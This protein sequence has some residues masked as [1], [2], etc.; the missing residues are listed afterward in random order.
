[1]KLKLN[2]SIISST[3]LILLTPTSI[4]AQARGDIG[5]SRQP[6]TCPSRSEPRTGVINSAQAIKYATCEAEADRIIRTPGRTN[7]IDISSLEVN[8]KPRQA[9][10]LDINYFGKAIANSPVYDVRGT[11]VAYACAAL[12]NSAGGGRPG[13]NCLN[14]N[15][16]DR[17]PN[18]SVGVCFR[19]PSGNW[20]C[21]LSVGGGKGLQYGPPP[22]GANASGSSET[23]IAP[24]DN[25]QT[26]FEQARIKQQKKDYRGSLA[27]LNRAIKISPNNADFYHYRA[28]IKH[29]IE[30]DRGSLA[31]LNRAIQINPNNASFYGDRGRVKLVS[32]KDRS[33][34]IKDWQQAANLFRQQGDTKQYQITLSAI[35]GVKN[36]RITSETMKLK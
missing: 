8:P 26:Y 10:Y 32:L 27:D 3:M 5:T 13:K 7:F 19:E 24:N 11:A 6:Q 9:E 36:G 33:G 17:G 22:D 16:D 30:D 23:Q 31:D 12:S 21:R 4:K 18:N 20:R 14:T 35:E 15:V 1:M 2:I 25:G 28:F 29:K 34:A